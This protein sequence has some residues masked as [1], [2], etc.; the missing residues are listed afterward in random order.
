MQQNLF[1]RTFDVSF[2]IM[3]ADV[4]NVWNILLPPPQYSLLLFS[5]FLFSQI[6]SNW[7]FRFD[8]TFLIAAGGSLG[9]LVTIW[10]LYRYKACTIYGVCGGQILENSC[11]RYLFPLQCR[12]WALIWNF[13]SKSEELARKYL[14][15]WFYN[16]KQNNWCKTR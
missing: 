7:Y 13:R 1:S 10:I 3:L 11:A 12:P 14:F 6:F 4:V 16:Q 15:S 8:L 2:L 5:S 9:V